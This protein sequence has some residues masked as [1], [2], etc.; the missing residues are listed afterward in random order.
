MRTTTRC[1]I[2]WLSLLLLVYQ[3][4]DFFTAASRRLFSNKEEKGFTL[5]VTGDPIN[6][7]ASVDT[8]HKCGIIDVPDI[9]ARVYVDKDD[10]THM[11]EGSTQFHRMTGPSPL[12]VTRE[13]KISWNMTG[14]PNPA[15]FAGDEFL[16]STF[17]F[18]NNGTV[19]SLIHTEYPGNRF[20]NCDL[21]K[22]PY[23]L[24]FTVSIG[25]AVSHDFGRTWNHAR[26]PPHHRVAAV[27]YKYNQS[28]PAS[29]WG[30][31]SNILKSPKDGYY[32][33][34]LWNKHTVGLQ[35][36]GICMMRSN[37]L[38][39]PTSWRAWNGSAFSVRFVSPYTMEPGQ[40]SNHICTILK[41]LPSD[42][43]AAFGLVWSAYLEKYVMTLGCS[44]FQSNATF[45]ISTSDDLV[46]WD[47]PTPF[48]SKRSL[49]PHV[50]NKVVAV[51]YPVFIDPSAP[52]AFHDKNFF[53]IGKEAYLYFSSTGH[54]THTDGRHLW[55]TP[56]KFM[57]TTSLLSQ[58]SSSLRR[59]PS[60]SRLE[61]LSFLSSRIERDKKPS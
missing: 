9:P 58:S 37:N 15:M 43:C 17:S 2:V 42:N 29:G 60:Q 21:G 4:N 6:V 52:I 10:V 41:D 36:P 16:D 54:G 59:N 31:L 53:T 61:F 23:P 24:C 50:A 44:G 25:L 40:E 12:N 19:V 48:Y 5:K 20:D 11:I 47:E 3:K 14:D 22:N 45:F 56:V 34:A 18:D 51:N 46:H 7:W 49:P 26:P 38:V 35:Q 33:V 30:D 13:C 8:L 39:E 57:K 27:P 1:M 28:Q 32:Y 55:A